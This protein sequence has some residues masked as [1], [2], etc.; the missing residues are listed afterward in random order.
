VY[1]PVLLSFVH[2]QT[3]YKDGGSRELDGTSKEDLMEWWQQEVKSF[4][5][6][7]GCTSSEQVEE[8]NQGQLANP[9]SFGKLPLNCCEHAYPTENKTVGFQHDTVWLCWI[10]IVH[11]HCWLCVDV[12][13]C[14]SANGYIY[15]LEAQVSLRDH[16]LWC[17]LHVFVNNLLSVD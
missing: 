14:I 11:F 6:S 9:G 16:V 3:L 5:L 7:L 2:C 1:Y 8:D 4:G 13:V 10:A 12:V 17:L 15:K